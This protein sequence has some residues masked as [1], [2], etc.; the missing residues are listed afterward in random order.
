MSSWRRIQ[1]VFSQEGTWAQPPERVDSQGGGHLL[2]GS[3]WAGSRDPRHPG[4]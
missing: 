4:L 2:Q 3:C 1:G